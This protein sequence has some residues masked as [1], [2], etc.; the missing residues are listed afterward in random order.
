[1]KTLL[2][3]TLLSIVTT[4]LPIHCVSSLLLGKWTFWLDTHKVTDVYSQNTC[5]HP[6]PGEKSQTEKCGNLFLATIQKT[7]DSTV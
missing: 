6:V 5:Q 3:L 2:L 7:H 1:M 4:D